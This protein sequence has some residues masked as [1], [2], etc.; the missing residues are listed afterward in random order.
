MIRRIA[1]AAM[2]SRTRRGGACR[3]RW[4]PDGARIEIS[5]DFD[6]LSGFNDKRGK[7]QK[8]YYYLRDDRKVRMS[9]YYA[10]HFEASEIEALTGLK[11]GEDRPYLTEEK[12]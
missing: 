4:A 10:N 8:G 6:D 1:C 2:R 11:V 5:Y 3:S 7:L 12:E 9:A